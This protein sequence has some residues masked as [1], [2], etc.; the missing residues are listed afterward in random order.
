MVQ[1]LSYRRGVVFN[2]PFHGG[3]QGMRR[4]SIL[5]ATFL[6]IVKGSYLFTEIGVND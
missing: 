3:F 2:Q 1:R 5:A 6:E 4:F